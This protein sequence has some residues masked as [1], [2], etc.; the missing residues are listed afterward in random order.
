MTAPATHTARIVTPNGAAPAEFTR[1]ETARAL[2]ATRHRLWELWN[3][4]GDVR[5]KATMR[6]P[7]EEAAS[8]YYHHVSPGNCPICRAKTLP[9]WVGEGGSTR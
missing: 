5:L 7:V 9:P 2:D 4:A 8:T 3:Q 6:G 1:C